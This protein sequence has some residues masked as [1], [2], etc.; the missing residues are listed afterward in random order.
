MAHLF[1]GAGQV[2]ANPAPASSTK[3]P[4]RPKFFVIASCAI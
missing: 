3:L 4:D 1:S 2:S